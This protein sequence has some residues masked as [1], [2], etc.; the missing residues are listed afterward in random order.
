MIFNFSA[1]AGG[2]ELAKILG[3]DSIQAGWIAA[4]YG[5]VRT[6]KLLS[7]MSLTFAV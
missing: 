3:A 1:V 6:Y 2:V 5:Y 4:S 7:T